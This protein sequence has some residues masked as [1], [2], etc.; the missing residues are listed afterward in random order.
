M[1]DIVNTLKAGSGID[2]KTLAKSLTDTVRGPQQAAI[3]AKKTA[4]NAKVSSVGKI[5]S[6]V[7]TFSSA[8][9][10][11]GNPY[12]FQRTPGSG[13]PS[14]V[15]IDFVD[16]ST[17]PTFTGRVAV[18]QLATETSILFPPLASL[19][20]DL[21]GGDA[22]RTLKLIA[23]N[24][25]APGSELATIDLKSIN[26]LPALRDQINQI[27]GFEATIIKG[28]TEAAPLYYLGMKGK[29]GEQNKFFASVTTTTNNVTSDAS[30]AG[31]FLN[32]AEIVRLGRDALIQVDG[33]QV[34]SS[35]NVFTNVLPGVEITALAT[36]NTDV[37]LSSNYNSEALSNAMA[38]MVSG[39][40]LMLET[41]KAETTFSSDP[42]TRGAL[43][44][45]ASTRA[46][47]SELR[48]FTTQGIAGFND[49][50]HTL[51][52]LGVRTNRDGTLTLDE[53]AFA[54]SLK[55]TPEI[56]EAVLASKKQITDSRL[57]IISST[58]AQTGKY[59]ISKDNA[60]QW[61]INDDLATI[62]AGKLNGKVGS[63]T[64]G[65]V[66]GLPPSVEVSAPAGYSTT[67][68][69]S[70]GLVE[71][72][73]DMFKSIMSSQT[74]IQI[75]S[76]NSNKS[77]SNISTE[78][79]KLDTK[80]KAMEERYLKQFTQMNSAVSAGNNVQSSLKTFI[81]SWTAG[82]KG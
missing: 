47:L 43:A 53:A 21:A 64:D 12:S 52:E 77:L 74:A 10:A 9:T 26:T 6:V 3:D 14:K 54:R 30:G 61:K 49:G 16:G 48:R 71:R 56:V 40:N 46:L 11:V 59:T 73:T 13:D 31:F 78:Q 24:A 27:A 20:E 62:M 81:D 57:S 42:K 33:V 34:S 75:V 66:I 22:N 5:M 82:L 8:M 29:Q 60:G 37:T 58:G 36:T 68:Y 44:N 19:D 7:N 79:I 15:K 63:A 17:A 1:V 18:D 70:K 80:M 65:L 32:G 25:L 38:T 23:G 45:E 55:Q 51:A 2:I 72:L 39:F 28:G 4:L 50:S 35:T 41:I 76:T 67:V 69:Y